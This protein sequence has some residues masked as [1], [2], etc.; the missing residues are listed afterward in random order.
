M[1][2]HAWSLEA[3]QDFTEGAFHQILALRKG[4]LDQLGVEGH[5]PR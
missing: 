1:G 3:I 4:P 5:P 2:G